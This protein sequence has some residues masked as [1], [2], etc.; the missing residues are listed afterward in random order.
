MSPYWITLF[1][2]FYEDRLK[3]GLDCKRHVSPVLTQ[4]YRGK[5]RIFAAHPLFHYDRRETVHTEGKAV[6]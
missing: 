2:S 5:R 3:T 4:H 1:A 6:G